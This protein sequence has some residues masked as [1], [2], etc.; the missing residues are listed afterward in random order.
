MCEVDYIDYHYLDYPTPKFLSNVRLDRVF[1]VV[2]ARCPNEL[3]DRQTKR[4]FLW[5]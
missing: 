2:V 1:D 3:V 5:S 4:H